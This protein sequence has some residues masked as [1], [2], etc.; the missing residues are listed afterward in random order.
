MD[1]TRRDFLK[2]TTTATAAAAAAP[3]ATIDGKDFEWEDKKPEE[4]L[5]EISELL[6][7][8]AK[9]TVKNPTKV[10]E[11]RPNGSWA[12]SSNHYITQTTDDQFTYHIKVADGNLNGQVDQRSP[13]ST[14]RDNIEILAEPRKKTG[15]KGNV[16]MIQSFQNPEYTRTTLVNLSAEP[17]QYQEVATRFGFGKLKAPYTSKTPAEKNINGKELQHVSFTTGAS[18]GGGR[19]VDRASRRIQ[20]RMLMSILEN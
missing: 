4:Q 8:V 9:R 14:S 12:H 2:A 18:H 16:R 19:P 6:V 17:R 13:G 15:F 1:M 10:K 7:R 11:V 20:R 3:Y 5:K